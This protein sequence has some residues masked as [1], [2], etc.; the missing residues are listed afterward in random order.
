MSGNGS[1][2]SNYSEY[3]DE[4]YSNYLDEILVND[5]AHVVIYS[6]LKV[7]NIIGDGRS[8]VH[9]APQTSVTLGG[10]MTTHCFVY[11][12]ATLN[13]T[14]PTVNVGAYLYVK[15]TLASTPDAVL[16][17]SVPAT[18]YLETQDVTISQLLIE[19]TANMTVSSANDTVFN[20][21]VDTFEVYGKFIAGPLDFHN[22]TNFIVG[23]SAV[24]EF[25]PIDVDEHL[26]S[27]IEIRGAVTLGHEV[28]FKRPCTQLLIDSGSLFWEVTENTTITLECERVVINGPFAPGNVNFGEGI[29]EFSVGN[30]GTF[31]FTAL[32][33]AYMNG[34]AIAGRMYAQNYAEFKSKNGT[35]NKID[36]FII[37]YP[38][39]SLTLNND[40]QPGYDGN[41]AIMENVTCST[42]HVDNLIVDGTFTA[43]TLDIG[44]G[45]ESLSING[46]FLFTPCGDYSIHELWV[47]GT[48]TSSLPLTLKGTNVERTHD[49]TITAHG[50]VKFD[51]NVLTSKEWTG[52]SELGI[53]NMEV[54][55]EFHAGRMA[56]RIAPDGGWDSLSVGQAGKLYF[57]PDGPFILDYMSV[58]GIFQAY[59]TIDIYTMRP[60][61]DLIIDVGSNA[62]VRFDS[63]I[64][65]GWTNLS[66]VT[67]ETFQTSSSSY[68]SVGDARLDIAN[69][70][71]GGS[72]HAYPS[73]LISAYYFEVT[74]TGSAD[75][76]RT[77]DIDG[78]E[79]VI[80]G[81]LDVSY[82]HDPENS[83]DGSN[84][85]HITYNDVTVSGTLR[86]GSIHMEAN[87]LRVTGTMDVSGGGY[88]SDTGPG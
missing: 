9:F 56:N 88:I 39:G 69:L 37:H 85:T 20:F 51:N 70:I 12:E 44:A 40:A 47:N 26:G 71:I 87:S 57:E 13:I 1:S 75:I 59:S 8:M 2:Y 80:S 28:S 50:I 78:L 76:S 16:T 79:M 25:D 74:G 29:E 14:T 46:T 61:A 72:F 58:N 68:V 42:L 41:G 62:N 7:S 17:L 52:T 15:G 48:M 43:D 38:S 31:T 19:E 66:S 82:Q 18:V 55:G 73:Q 81:T 6:S 67:A 23:S 30:S 86:A 4:D 60:E 33:P 83:T 63:L 22:I 64:S 27:N 11:E 34:V 5:G 77:V 49:F 84:P 3:L 10:D 53:H 54:S 45:L 21:Q 36:Y 32:G 65:S 24:V 35:G